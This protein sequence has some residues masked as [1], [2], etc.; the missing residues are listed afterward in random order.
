M[1]FLDICTESLGDSP[2]FIGLTLSDETCSVAHVLLKIGP[3][4]S[5]DETS[6]D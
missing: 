1:T 4:V 5:R 3:L 2:S 6:L